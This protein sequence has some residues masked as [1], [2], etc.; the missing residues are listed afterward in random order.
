MRPFKRHYRSL[1]DTLGFPLTERSTTPRAVI[2]AAENRLGVKVPAALR[3]YYLVAGREKRL[4]QCLNRLLA[5]SKWWIDKGRLVFMEE[6]QTVAWWAVSTRNRKSDDPA[7]YQGWNDE[8]IAWS[9][10]HSSCS[11]FLAVM[12]HYHAVS[13]GFP[14]CGRADAP[15]ESDYRFERNGWMYHGKVNSVSAYSRQNEAVCLMPP[16]DL[17]FMEGWS[18]LAGAKSAASLKKLGQEI[19]V[20]F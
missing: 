17:P 14:F 11:I 1:F 18:V 15:R 13:D 19:G 7:V 2:A 4:N 12:L 5:P 10:E 8:P 9:L 20:T 6:N 16:G 3:D